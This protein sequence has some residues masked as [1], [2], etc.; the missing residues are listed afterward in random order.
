MLSRSKKPHMPG[1]AESFLLRCGA[2]DSGFITYP[3]FVDYVLEHD[4][5]LAIAFDILNQSKNGR[6][7]KDDIC[8]TFKQFGM[9]VSVDEAELLARRVDQAGNLSIN[10]T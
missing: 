8:E 2:A 5:R 4:K 1:V 10:Y 6:V 7:T 3:E 9:P